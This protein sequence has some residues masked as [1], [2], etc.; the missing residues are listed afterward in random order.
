[1]H[2]GPLLILAE[3]VTGAAR[4]LLLSNRQRGVLD[5]VAAT[6]SLQG[7]QRRQSYE[8]IAI[9]TNAFFFAKDRADRLESAE[10]SELGR[11][12][13]VQVS[14]DKLA[15]VGGAGHQA[16]ID[17]RRRA[18]RGQLARAEDEDARRKLIERLGKLAGGMAVLKLGA[19]S[20]T[21]RAVRK[22]LAE[23][24]IRFMPMALEE[25]V[26]PGGGAAYL[27]CQ[28]ALAPIVDGSDEE[29]VGAALVRDALESPM[30][31]L[32]CNAGQ[33]SAS[34]LAEVRRH[35][36]GFGYDVIGERVVDMWSAN[37]LDA[38]KVARVALETAVS[39][40]AMALTTEAIVLRRKPAVS[41]A[42]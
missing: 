38:T 22:E 1:M 5:V 11:A 8:D 17:E 27:A 10:I 37:I 12:R 4:A 34:I 24:F 29:A 16:L 32:T 13:L 6:L 33:A 21:E 25:G 42:P 14:T 30:A 15:I 28:P 40:A 19:A 3:D 23:R 39:V 26:V 36:A 41:L 9:I 18:L 20:H 2:T 31:C 7:N 35:G